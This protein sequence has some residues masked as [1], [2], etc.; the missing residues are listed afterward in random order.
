MY[1]RYSVSTSLSVVR[2]DVH[3]SELWLSPTDDS[4]ALLSPMDDS[5]A[6]PI[7]GVLIFEAHI[8]EWKIY[9]WKYMVK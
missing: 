2:L 1:G 8:Y 5:W 6:E 7:G 9:E 4:W 3:F